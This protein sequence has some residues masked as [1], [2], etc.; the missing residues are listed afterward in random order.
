[1]LPS[2][3]REPTYQEIRG[4]FVAVIDGVLSR[5][6]AA[7]WSSYWII[8]DRY[9]RVENKLVWE[10]IK[11]LTGVDLET[12]PGEYLHDE[13]DFREMLASFDVESKL[14]S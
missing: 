7:D 1:M 3:D 2:Q 4:V 11:Y 8:N 6:E 12:E 5:E 13:D 10:V 9:K 14:K